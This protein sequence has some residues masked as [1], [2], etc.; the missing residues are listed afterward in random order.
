MNNVYL[1]INQSK[2]RKEHQI[3]RVS[4]SRLLAF[5][6]SQKINQLLQKRTQTQKILQLLSQDD[7]PRARVCLGRSY[8]KRA[9]SS[10][11][12]RN[13]RDIRADNVDFE[14]HWESTQ[15]KPK[16]RE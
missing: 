16:M 9:G 1:T 4:V 7:T 2:Q 3:H 13:G 10:G 12:Q 15:K 6:T 11:R 5:K 8:F 14:G